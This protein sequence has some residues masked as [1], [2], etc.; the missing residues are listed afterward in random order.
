[1]TRRFRI[2]TLAAALAAAT[3]IAIAAQP[4]QGRGPDG[5]GR[6]G[7][8][9]P[10]PMP[11]LRGLALSDSQR[12]QIR[13]ITDSHRGTPGNPASKVAHLQQQLQL[14]IFS[15]PPDQG[16]IEELKG[17]I[18]AAH[19]EELTTRIDVESRIAQVLTPEQRAQARES[20]EKA[21]AGPPP[22]PG[23]RRGGRGRQ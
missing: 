9:G 21:P 2:A 16:K 5:G 18:A 15:E 22:G 4:P 1:M 10:G 7:P 14:A 12:E 8:G 17:A 13:A 23:G 6:M 11:L 20:L 3:T 19:A